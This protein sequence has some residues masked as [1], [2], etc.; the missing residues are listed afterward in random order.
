MRFIF[1]ALLLLGLYADLW[2]QPAIVD[3]PHATFSVTVTVRVPGTPEEVYDALTGDISGWWDH[4]FH[5]DAARFFIDARP[6]GGF[7]EYFDPEGQNGVRHGVVTF[8]QRGKKLVYI[9]Q[10][11]F[12]GTGAHITVSYDLRSLDQDMT[13]LTAKATYV[14]EIQEGWREAKARVWSHFFEDRFKTYMEAGCHKNEDC[15]AFQNQE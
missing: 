3:Q 14:G 8:A 11:G 7:F 9:G 2:A 15:G 5:P 13:E 1:I 12:L 6:G 4:T 10:L